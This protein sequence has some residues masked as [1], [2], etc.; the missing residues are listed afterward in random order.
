MTGLQFSV[1]FNGAFGVSIDDLGLSLDT[2]NET[3]VATKGNTTVSLLT[4]GDRGIEWQVNRASIGVPFGING[5][6]DAG[7]RTKAAALEKLLAKLG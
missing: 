3:P 7:T 6:D 5:R 4:V 2:S 1:L